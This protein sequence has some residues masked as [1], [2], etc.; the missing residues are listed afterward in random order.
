MFFRLNYLF[1]KLLY[2][3][4]IFWRV[5]VLSVNMEFRRIIKFFLIIGGISVYIIDFWIIKCLV[6][7]IY[8]VY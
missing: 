8:I 4:G 3:Y 5:V 6:Y 7:K 1:V 2:K